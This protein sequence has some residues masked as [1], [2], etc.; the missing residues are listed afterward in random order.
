MHSDIIQIRYCS[1]TRAVSLYLLQKKSKHADWNFGYTKSISSHALVS[2]L[3]RAYNTLVPY[4][5][6]AVEIERSHE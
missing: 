3:C 4:I 1:L 5:N 2:S 6:K